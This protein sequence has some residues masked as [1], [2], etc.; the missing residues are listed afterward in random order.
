MCNNSDWLQYIFNFSNYNSCFLLIH[1]LNFIFRERGREGEMER[2]MDQLPLA[3]APTGQN[4][5]P[6]HIP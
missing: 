1:F 2:N 6:R 5:L 3:C 4:P